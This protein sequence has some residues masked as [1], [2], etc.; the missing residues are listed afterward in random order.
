MA[1]SMAVESLVTG[2]AAAAWLIVERRDERR[3]VSSIDLLP[4][5][6]ALPRRLTPREDV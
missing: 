2:N 1:I 6:P 4:R 3:G 5:Y